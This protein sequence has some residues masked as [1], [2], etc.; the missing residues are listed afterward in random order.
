MPKVGKIHS[1]QF[2]AE[3][4]RAVS[5]FVG[6]KWA[7]DE[8]IGNTASAMHA[9]AT[10]KGR[11]YSAF[12][13]EGTKVFSH[14]QFTQEA[15]GLWHIAEN[16]DVKTPDVIDVLNIDGTTLLVMEAIDAKPVEA[17]VDYEILAQGMAQLHKVTRDMYGFESDNYMGTLAQINTPKSDWLDFFA[18]VR[19]RESFNTL[20][21]REH[22]GKT[23]AARLLERLEQLFFK[24]PQIIG[25]NNAR[26]SLMHGDAWLNNMLFDGKQLVLIAPSVY[27]GER[28]MDISTWGLT[29]YF[30]KGCK[31]E[32][33]MD[34]Y[35][36][37]YP[38]ELGYTEREELW[39]L[40]QYLCFMTYGGKFHGLG[41]DL[42]AQTLDKYL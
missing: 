32:Y 4:E 34:A 37:I 6:E 35:N 31:Q 2:N 14:D 21:A 17:K 22:I 36:E 9:A 8:I 42:V 12:V 18:N 1:G 39:R 11:G 10:F 29:K 7:I 13:K 25:T 40:N 28:E 16:S 27:Y 24:L 33:F 15:K 19:I 41:T 26:P 5:M 3:I 20:A 38:F 23:E 30:E